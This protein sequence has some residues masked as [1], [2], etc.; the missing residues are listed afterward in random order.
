MGRLDDTEISK[1]IITAY[2]EKLHARILSD[3]IIVG[4]GPA[5]MT[6]AAYLARDGF[7][8]TVL[9]RRLAAGGG[10]WGGGTGMSEAIVQDDALPILDDMNI[11]HRPVAYGLHAVDAMEMAAG[12]CVAAIQSGA[13]MFN[14]LMVEDVAVRDGRVFG[15]VVNR[16]MIGGVLP[17]DPI[18]FTSKVVIDTTGHEGIVVAALRKHRLLADSPAADGVEGPMNADE[19][20]KFVVDNVSEIYPG[21]WVSGMSVCSTLGGSRMGPIFGGMLLSGKRVADLIAAQLR[22]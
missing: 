9:E 20:E 4:A 22:S 10:V 16:S 7:N 3:V 21:L 6:A 14:L 8:V 12:L 2:S 13:G 11:K 19:G 1:A 18:T 17:V 5:G 15:V